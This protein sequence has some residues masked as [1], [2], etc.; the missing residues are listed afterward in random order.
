MAN[1]STKPPAITR[2]INVLAKNL[3]NRETTTA[4]AADVCVAC[5]K[6][7]TEF[8]DERS[9]REFEISGLCQVCQDNVFG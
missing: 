3:F 2:A 1:R 7:A 4:I 8:K 6:V 5:G 9:R